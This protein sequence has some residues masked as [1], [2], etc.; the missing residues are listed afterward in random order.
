ME[1]RTLAWV[2]VINE[3][4]CTSL[5]QFLE[6]ILSEKCSMSKRLFYLLWKLRTIFGTFDGVRLSTLFQTLSLLYWKSPTETATIVANYLFNKKFNRKLFP[7]VLSAGMWWV[8]KRTLQTDIK[9]KNEK[10]KAKKKNNIEKRLYQ[11]SNH[12]PINRKSSHFQ[13]R[14]EGFDDFWL[15]KSLFF[16]FMVFLRIRPG[17]RSSRSPSCA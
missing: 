8:K 5:S 4:A 16:S 12:R 11:R 10:K 3:R 15:S 7:A 6:R 13:L 2:L 9:K 17:S 1:H 14:H